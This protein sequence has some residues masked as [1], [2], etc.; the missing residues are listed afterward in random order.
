[1]KNIIVVLFLALANLFSAQNRDSVNCIKA[2]NKWV[3]GECISNQENNTVKFVLNET[4]L[5]GA[6]L[7]GEKIKVNKDA[8]SI[9]ITNNSNATIK[10]DGK[11]LN[12]KKSTTISKI[13]KD[14]NVKINER[15]YK[16]IVNVTTPAAVDPAPA[17]KVDASNNIPNEIFIKIKDKDSTTIGSFT[18]YV[19]DSGNNQSPFTVYNNSKKLHVFLFSINAN[20]GQKELWGEIKMKQNAE[21]SYEKDGIE[22]VQTVKY[23]VAGDKKGDKKLHE[24]SIKYHYND[25]I[26]A[27]GDQ[28]SNAPGNASE[29]KKEKSNWSKFIIF[30]SVFLAT[31]AGLFLLLKKLKRKNIPEQIIQNTAQNPTEKKSSSFAN[32][33]SSTVVSS[34]SLKISE[35]EKRKIEKEILQKI[36]AG[37]TPNYL[38][39]ETEVF[40]KKIETSI[41]TKLNTEKQKQIAEIIVQKDKELNELKVKINS[42]EEKEN[43]L[44][45]EKTK[46]QNVITQLNITNQNLLLDKTNLNNELEKEKPYSNEMRK[47]FNALE[48]TYKTLKDME[49]NANKNSRFYQSLNY[50]LQ[51]QNMRSENAIFNIVKSNDGLM[52]VLGVNSLKDLKNISKETFFNRYINNYF[53]RTLTSIVQLYAYSEANGSLN[54]STEMKNDGFE[55]MKPI[56]NNLNTAIKEFGYSMMVPNLG[57][58]TYDEQKQQKSNN[59]TLMQIAP[60]KIE[61]VTSGKIYDVAR[62]GFED[63]SG[64]QV[65]KTTVVCKL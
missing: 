36:N 51:G 46:L 21:F 53:E 4:N 8:A 52:E 64:N 48:F 6:I 42:V 30:G 1:M 44:T 58:D 43:G 41:S 47:F 19:V 20:S 49:K 26:V 11:I 16:I 63:L 22:S 15:V 61:N 34:S 33:T 23:L 45:I 57:I 39:N 9:T 10:I 62:I 65:V 2:G 54:T 56:F 18:D 40:R 25:H 17:K 38:Q 59:S 50:I 35:D 32:S 7:Q 5:K 37:N 13:T 3:N 27:N 28:I 24:F 31:L 29:K 55:N 14:R 60:E 12:K